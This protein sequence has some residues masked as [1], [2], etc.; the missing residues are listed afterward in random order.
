[1]SMDRKFAGGLVAAALLALGAAG[2]AA[3]KGRLASAEPRGP[4]QTAADAG[5]TAKVKT[6]LA[7]DE[8]VKARRI[9]VDTVR[10]VVQLSGTVGSMAEKER[11]LSIARG[12]SGVNE[13]RDN[14]KASS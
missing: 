3:D 14:L 2:C 6:A 8:L 7:A 5:I 9:D 4:V 13:V 12:V 11:A 1:M 10:G